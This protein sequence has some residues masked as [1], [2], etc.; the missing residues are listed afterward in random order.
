MLR[1]KEIKLMLADDIARM[2]PL[3]KLPS[4]LVLCKKYD[5]TR[6]TLDKAIK[7]LETEGVVFCKD[8]SGTYVAVPEGF[9]ITKPRNWG[10]IVPDIRED[11][12]A[13][14]VRGIEDV[15]LKNQ[16]NL[17]LC[18]FDHSH[19]KQEKY[20]RRLMLTGVSGMIIVPVLRKDSIET[21]KLYS[22]LIESE[23]PVVFCNMEVVGIKA[24]VVMS[25]GFYGGYIATKHLIEKGY[26]N[27]AY[28][29]AYR[30]RTSEER[31]QG[32]IS[33]LLES[34]IEIDRDLMILE[35]SIDTTEP[36]GYTAMKKILTDKTV[37]AVFCFNDAIAQGVYK[38]VE[39]ADKKIPED[40]GIIG[41]DNSA[42]CIRLQPTLTSVSYRN[43]EI[44]I[45]AAELLQKQIDGLFS[46]NF[47]YY[48]LQPEIME[49]DSSTGPMTKK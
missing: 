7:E 26:R 2:N 30:Y 43:F 47:P 41:Y 34:G 42:C 38:A 9:D 44:G 10:V 33:A 24:P 25:S 1:Y 12:Y 17:I 48:L 6:T 36:S 19:G 46:P 49:R 13:G 39:E 18:N 40:I 32:Y 22:I 8:G 28:I 31:C 5:T 27:I 15:A 11:I 4:R 20:I 16:T 29:S 14:L 23:K 37:D 35:D 45:M 21:Q 3:D